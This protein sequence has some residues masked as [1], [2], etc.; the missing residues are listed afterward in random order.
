MHTGDGVVQ[1]VAV[2]AVPSGDRELQSALQRDDDKHRPGRERDRGL[3]RASTP[4]PTKLEPQRRAFGGAA[5]I[6]ANVGVV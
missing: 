6:A 5:A 2:P 1:L 3:L 4:R